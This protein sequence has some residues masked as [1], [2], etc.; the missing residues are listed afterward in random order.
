MTRSKAFNVGDSVYVLNAISLPK[1]H[2]VIH[3][4]TIERVTRQSSD[5][6]PLYWI[7]DRKTAVTERVLRHAEY[8]LPSGEVVRVD[9]TATKGEPIIDF[10]QRDGSIVKATVVL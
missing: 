8:R 5:G 10:T 6:T 4:G 2:I 1:R 9:A 7:S 3:Y